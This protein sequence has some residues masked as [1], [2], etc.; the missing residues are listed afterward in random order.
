[1]PRNFTITDGKRRHVAAKETGVGEAGRKGAHAAELQIACTAFD[2]QTCLTTEK[3]ATLSHSAIVG[4]EAAFKLEADLQPIAEIF[5]AANP[6]TGSGGL[7][8]GHF[9]RINS[10][11]VGR[12]IVNTRESKTDVDLAIHRHFSRERRGSKSC[13]KCHNK[14]GFLHMRALCL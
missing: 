9:Q 7:T 11:A 10:I 4:I 14:S 12:T 1:M 3:A 5:L 2:E 13:S 8:A 6:P